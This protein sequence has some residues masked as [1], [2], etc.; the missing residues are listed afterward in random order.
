MKNN[1]KQLRYESNYVNPDFFAA[2]P[3]TSIW[4]ELSG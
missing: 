3:A 4:S 2:I 1:T